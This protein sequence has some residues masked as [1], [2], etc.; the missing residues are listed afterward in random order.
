M[1]DKVKLITTTSSKFLESSSTKE[2]VVE[3]V[4]PK[5]K[6]SLNPSS[7]SFDTKFSKSSFPFMFLF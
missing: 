6:T 3:S 7:I 1:V 5:E 2:D 4:E